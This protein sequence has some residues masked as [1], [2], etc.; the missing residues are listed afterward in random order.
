MIQHMSPKQQRRIIKNLARRAGGGGRD[1][2]E[3]L[4]IL[5]GAGVA[6][7]RA[8]AALRWYRDFPTH[9]HRRESL[10]ILEPYQK[11]VVAFGEQH[12]ALRENDGPHAAV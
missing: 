6:R 2:R 4:R 10:T 11:S 8:L 5:E 1:T 9:P 3:V 7:P 12:R